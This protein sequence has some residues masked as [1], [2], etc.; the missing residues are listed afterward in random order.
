MYYSHF[1]G[2]YFS[3]CLLFQI[4]QFFLLVTGST[5]AFR[6]RWFLWLSYIYWSTLTLSGFMC[7]V[8]YSFTPKPDVIAIQFLVFFAG[9]TGLGVIVVSNSEEASRQ[10][11]SG[12]QGRHL[13][14][15]DDTNKSYTT[16]RVL[17]D[18]TVDF[19]TGRASRFFL[20]FWRIFNR[21]LKV[22]HWAM[23]V[24]F[25]AGGITLALS[26]RFENPYVRWASSETRA[27]SS[28]AKS[29]K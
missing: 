27:D 25:I 11:G 16:A 29:P 14:S 15:V 23:S 3:S 19:D 5:R 22:V 13:E 2:L 1:A 6:K 9:L 8:C 28:E 10:N 26:Y 24:M 12:S 20:S 7:A 4:I 17:S 18:P 21:F